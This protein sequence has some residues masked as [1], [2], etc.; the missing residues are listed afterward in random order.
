MKESLVKLSAISIFGS[1]RFRDS[2]EIWNIRAKPKTSRFVKALNSS[3]ELQSFSDD[4]LVV[5]VSDHE[6][7]IQA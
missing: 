5:R 3:G 1:F 6:A 2:P 7:M 4:I